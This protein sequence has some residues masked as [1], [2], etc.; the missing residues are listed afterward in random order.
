[1]LLLSF[2]WEATSLVPRPPPSQRRG[3][4]RASGRPTWSSTCVSL[5]RLSERHDT[6]YSTWVY[7]MHV[8]NHTAETEEATASLGWPVRDL[9][10]ELGY[11]RRQCRRAPE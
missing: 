6:C 9:D 11:L 2:A 7:R 1:M 8:A 4:S 3:L 10:C 5:L